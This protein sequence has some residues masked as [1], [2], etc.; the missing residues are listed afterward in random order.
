[1]DA[2][3]NDVLIQEETEVKSGTTESH[4]E[5]DHEESSSEAQQNCHFHAGVE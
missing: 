4:S 2:D 3:G 5:H 1:M